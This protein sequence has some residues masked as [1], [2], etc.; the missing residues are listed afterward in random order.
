M[1]RIAICLAAVA[2]LLATGTARAAH[3]GFV[4]LKSLDDHMN[5]APAFAISLNDWMLQIGREALEDDELEALSGVESVSVRIYEA[6]SEQLAG[7]TRALAAEL[8]NRGW[9]PVVQVRDDGDDVRVLMKSDGRDI[10]G[11]TV[12]VQSRGGE[13]VFVNAYGAI[14]PE[15][16]GRLLSRLGELG[17]VNLARLDAA[18]D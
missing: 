11:V 16:L 14:S 2:W 15:H 12:L 1:N 10:A 3:P 4:D 17:D 5:V 9:A 7:A 18:V 13:A 6:A 8:G